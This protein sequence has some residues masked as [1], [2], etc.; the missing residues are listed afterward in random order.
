MV[1]MKMIYGQ[2]AAKL[3]NRLRKRYGEGSE[4]RWLS[5]TN[6]SLANLM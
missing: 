5:V 3:L 4:T 2:S 6:E 1:K